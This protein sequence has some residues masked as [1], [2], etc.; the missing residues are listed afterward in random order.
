MDNEIKRR[1]ILVG[2][3][4]RRRRLLN[5][6]SSYYVPHQER[7]VST[8]QLGSPA[9]NDVEENSSD[10]TV[11]GDEVSVDLLS[12]SRLGSLTTNY[13]E[14]SSDETVCE[15]SIA[16]QNVPMIQTEQS[17]NENSNSYLDVTSC[18]YEAC[19]A[20]LSFKEQLCRWAVN[21]KIPHSHLNPLLTILKGYHPELPLDARILLLTPRK[22][23]L[24]SVLPGEYYHFGIASG[25]IKS[26]EPSELL[27][28]GLVVKI[29]IGIDG[30]PTS[31][32]NPGEFWPIIGQTKN[33]KNLNMFLIGLYHGN[34]KPSDVNCYLK[35][36][37]DEMSTIIEN[38]GITFQSKTIKVQ[39][40][41]FVCDAPAR[42]FIKCVKTHSGFS[43]CERC[44]IHGEFLGRVVFLDRN[45]PERNDLNFRS[46]TDPDHHRGKSILERLESV[47]LVKDFPLDYMHLI[48]LGVV[49]KFLHHLSVDHT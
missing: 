13:S 48:C 36:F 14:D 16:Y 5:A 42:A 25:I 1:K 33:T 27:I 20:S 41:G 40:I 30:I 32:S 24:R 10:E 31:K 34:K 47:D 2:A 4:Q 35:D 8:S 23:V 9:T 11:G 28:P 18:T 21:V 12:T 19:V 17:Q 49:K 39:V 6:V 37:V 26:L 45:C 44:D 15:A 3:R 29:L 43:S 46:Q 38:G 7:Q 22:I